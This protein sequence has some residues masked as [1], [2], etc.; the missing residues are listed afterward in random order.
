MQKLIT[1][2]KSTKDINLTYS[3]KLIDFIAKS[4]YD[5]QFGARP[6]KRFIQ[7]KVESVLAY[8]I[9]NGEINNQEKYQIDVFAGNFIINVIK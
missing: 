2:V 5:S 8:K 7:N 4:A 6:I 9:I 3:E 1:R